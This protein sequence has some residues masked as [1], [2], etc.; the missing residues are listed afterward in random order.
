MD[1][2][3]ELSE[4][5]L[6]DEAD[7]RDRALQLLTESYA[8]GASIL[9]HIFSAW[10]RWGPDAFASF[11]LVFY[12]P[13]DEDQ[14]DECLQRSESMVQRRSLTDPSSRAAGKIIEQ[15]VKLPA[16][17][18]VPF[19]EKLQRLKPQS[20]I[21]FRVNLETLR[22]R[23]ELLD[24]TADELANQLDAT[25]RALSTDR[26][27]SELLIRGEVLLE[28]LRRQHPSY[29]DLNSVL[30][31]P[32]AESG[33]EAVS[34]Q[35]SIQSLISFAE[36]GTEANLT[37]HLCDHREVVFTAIVES[38][39]RA[40]SP[41][42][43]ESFLE[44]FETAAESNR[45]WIARG[46]QRLRQPHLASAIA[47]LRN[48]VTDANLWLMLFIAEIGQLEPRGEQIA[49]QLAR[50]NSYSQD[51]TG[52]LSIYNRIQ[53]IGTP[54]PSNCFHDEYKKYLQ[55][56]NQ[57]LRQQVG[58]LTSKAKRLDLKHRKK[59]A[60]RLKQRRFHPNQE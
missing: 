40:N 15:L 60:E 31:Q 17:S 27:N 9:H 55:R 51:L 52:I 43:A 6:S 22:Q 56:C 33:P 36:P 21:F 1:V 54:N 47:E 5:L 37:K 53:K 32:C 57:D 41:Q 7:I 25:V 59:L 10:E 45:L 58:K 8:G 26:N 50:V 39:V 24:T 49:R 28:A 13:I 18:L 2:T 46:L 42:A 12:V 44:A 35:L 38:L 16:S 14:I 34:F 3:H 30:A 4:L 20:K 11:P 48:T 19:E 23:I 29:M